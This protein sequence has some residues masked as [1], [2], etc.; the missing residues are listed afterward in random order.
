MGA[1][2]DFQRAHCLGNL[3]GSAVCLDLVVF[4]VRVSL[5]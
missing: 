2:P 5:I 1:A 4:T 3:S